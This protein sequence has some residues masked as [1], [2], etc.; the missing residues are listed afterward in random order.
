[1]LFSRPGLAVCET[2]TTSEDDSDKARR[3]GERADVR[4][5]HV[6][7]NS[8]SLV[9]C[10]VSANDRVV[11]SAQGKRHRRV[12]LPASPLFGCQAAGAA[13]TFFPPR[14]AA[15]LLHFEPLGERLDLTL[16]EAP[17]P[18]QSNDVWDPAFL[19]PPADGFRGDVEEGRRFGRP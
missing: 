13:A 17:M 10:P 1:M 5:L 9:A 14:C 3:D 6:E 16:G 8:L 11:R 12:P 7:S 4:L 2:G 15:P 18:P 19:G